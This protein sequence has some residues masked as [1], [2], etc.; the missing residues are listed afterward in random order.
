MRLHE[1]VVPA[2]PD[3]QVHLGGL[4]ALL[5]SEAGL[6]LDILVRKC[7]KKSDGT[8]DLRNGS[9]LAE[10]SLGENLALLTC[11]GTLGFFIIIIGSIWWSGSDIQLNLF[12]ACLT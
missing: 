8:L 10:L 2:L 9:L 1:P 5:K 4:E 12:I 6:P 3:D 11:S 7:V